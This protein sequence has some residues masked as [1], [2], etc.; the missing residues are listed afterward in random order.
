[1]G[2]DDDR[3]GSGAPRALRKG[4]GMDPHAGHARPARRE[5]QCS[6]VDAGASQVDAS[7]VDCWF[8]LSQV[9]CL[10]GVE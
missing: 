7:Q 9:D 1:M 6:Q 2:A 5:G 3:D 10:T 4:G 8:L